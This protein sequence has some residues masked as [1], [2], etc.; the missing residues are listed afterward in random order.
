MTMPQVV[1]PPSNTHHR[2]TG[3]RQ[4]AL[5]AS[6]IHDKAGISVS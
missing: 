2:T 3:D 1:F 4:P 5:V 6:G